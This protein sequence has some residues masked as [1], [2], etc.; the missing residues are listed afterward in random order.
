MSDSDKPAALSPGYA[1]GILLSVPAGLILAMRYSG[2]LGRTSFILV[3]MAPAL[4]VCLAAYLEPR[5]RHRRRR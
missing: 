2:E 4:L 1:V 5:L 3:A